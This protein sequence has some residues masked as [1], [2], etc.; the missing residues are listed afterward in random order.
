MPSLSFPA[1]QPKNQKHKFQQKKKLPLQAV[2]P[3]VKKTAGRWKFKCCFDDCE[4]TDVTLKSRRK[5]ILILS[6]PTSE[7]PC[8][9]DD[10][11]VFQSYHTKLQQED[12]F[13][14]F[15]RKWHM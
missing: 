10:L 2:K 6:Y 3:I 7:P 13:T 1:P 4:N 9:D 14:S 5:C 8:N 15:I 12:F 11:E